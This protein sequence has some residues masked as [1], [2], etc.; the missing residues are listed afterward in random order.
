MNQ[1]KIFVDETGTFSSI[2]RPDNC[3][4]GG[5]VYKAPGEQEP[6]QNELAGMLK[7]SIKSFNKAHLNTDIKKLVYPRDMH[8]APLHTPFSIRN[9]K[10]R[11]LWYGSREEIGP[12]FHDAF[13]KIALKTVLM[14]RS[15]GLPAIIPHEQAAYF[16]ILRNTLIQLLKEKVFIRDSSL[17]ICIASRRTETLLGY[18]GI[19][20]PD[21]HESYLAE[22]L[23]EELVA[24]SKIKMI[25]IEF[26]G[27]TETP[28]LIWA[29]FFCGAMKEKGY[30]DDTMKAKLKIYPFAAGYRLI[31]LKSKE[32]LEY[33]HQQHP[34]A[35]L[36]H[37]IQV[38]TGI[39]GKKETKTAVNWLTLLQEIYRSISID[40]RKDFLKNIGNYIESNL[41]R[42][43]TRYEFL[44]EAEAILKALRGILPD[45]ADKMNT[46][47]LRLQAEIGLH[48]LRIAS[49]RGSYGSALVTA[50]V[51]FLQQYAGHIFSNRIEYAQHLVDA[52]LMAAQL[53]DFN[54]LSF[55]AVETTI[56]PVQELYQKLYMAADALGSYLKYDENF[57]KLKGTYAQMCGFLYDMTREEHYFTEAE[58]GFK[59]D[60]KA[61]RPDDHAWEQ[62]MGF[63][64]ALYWKKGDLAR[65]EAQ[66]CK[67]IKT[68][69]TSP[70]LYCLDNI[71]SLY[72]PR[73]KAFFLLH[74]LCLCALAQEKKSSGYVS[75][76][77]TI[78]TELLNN[79]RINR[80]PEMLSAK[81]LAV[82]FM[83][84]NDDGITMDSEGKWISENP[85]SYMVGTDYG[86][87]MQL[88]DAGEKV[89]P[90]GDDFTIG[91]IRL[92]IKML[93]HKCRL[94]LG[95]PSSFNLEREVR[96]L[97]ERRSGATDLL[98][99]M[100]LEKL[101][102]DPA[103]WDPYAVA[104]LPPFY[105][106]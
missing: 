24:A 12:F 96:N 30:F 48:R 21:E 6:Q 78:K 67:E 104:A 60:I 92:P 38:F 9:Q 79:P 88:L 73:K 44:D 75:G 71:A 15:Q 105:Y 86:C 99:R 93:A 84:S 55:E 101:D 53:Q 94:A 59:D 80:Y 10:Y 16:E 51:K 91:F 64:T 82:L 34:V 28:G 72:D 36:I 69:L 87:A 65:T 8:F 40:E 95:H 45:Q 25:E 2:D 14:F 63:L 22:K 61:C 18:A 49:H 19:K 85:K 103:N 46:D 43:S 56:K 17:R 102:K 97:E 26:S 7:N 33:L 100:G 90:R 50:H 89:L 42:K 5:W 39:S 58:Q 106:A 35:A 68:S 57:A 27:A 54:R 31:R 52:A 23:K 47:E 37:G 77:E 4:V 76:L 74:H 66:F 20:N 98:N 29:D 70:S 81:W 11:N 62:G 13:H 1:Y 83:K 32:K 41:T 3:F